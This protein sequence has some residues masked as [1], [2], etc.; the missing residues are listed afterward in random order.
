MYYTPIFEN[1]PLSQEVIVSQQLSSEYYNICSGIEL[2]IEIGKGAVHFTSGFI[3]L[4]ASVIT[5]IYRIITTHYL[6]V[7]QIFQYNCQNHNLYVDMHLFIYL[8]DML[9]FLSS[10]IRHINEL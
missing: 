5:S 10:G 9:A 8:I 2:D 4:R 3:S 6:I 1:S 7:M